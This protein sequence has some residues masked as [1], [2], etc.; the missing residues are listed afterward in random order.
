MV[1]L[2]KYDVN[3][4]RGATKIVRGPADGQIENSG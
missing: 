4:M 1:F 2:H 3:Q